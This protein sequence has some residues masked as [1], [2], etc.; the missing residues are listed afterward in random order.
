MATIALEGVEKKFGTT[1]VVDGL[2]LQ[3]GQGEL[4]ALVGP[5]GCG[6]TT[7]LRMIAGLTETSS[8]VIRFDDRDVTD[9]PTYRRNTG[10]VFQGYALFP[11]MSVA[12]NVAFGLQ[13][14]SVGRDATARMV[15]EAL[16][17]VRLE[18]YSERF[19]RQLSGGQQQRVALARAVAIKPDVLLLDEPLSALDAKLRAEVRFE[20]KR[21]QS[22]LNLTT[23]FV[24][25]DQE[26]AVS[27]ADRVVVMNAGR[28][29]QVGTPRDVYERPA[30][31]FV[32]NFIGLS[33]FIAGCDEG[34]G[35]FRSRTGHLL[36]YEVDRVAVGAEALAIRPEMIDLGDPPD[37]SQHNQLV[38]TID[39]VT[40]LGPVTDLEVLLD[41]GER[42]HVHRSNKQPGYVE[43]FRRGARL[44]LHWPPSA[45]LPV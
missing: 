45:S 31:R 32:A 10:I 33:N 14:R 39:A 7:T 19:P 41:S 16:A 24:T 20:I 12:D 11:H 38:G 30:T 13:M 6:K 15:R 4:V 8:G 25:H 29:E 5:S 44:N 23:V 37:G 22:S 35:R 26:E 27:I 42:L 28:V 3:I 2:S 43:Q 21:L 34:G 40:Y 18:E 1:V 17:L 9:L 36:R